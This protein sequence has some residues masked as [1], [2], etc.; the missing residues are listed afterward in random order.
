MILFLCHNPKST[1]CILLSAFMSQNYSLE[2][3]INGRKNATAKQTHL[4]LESLIM[5]SAATSPCREG[6]QSLWTSSAHPPATGWVCTPSDSLGLGYI[7]VSFYIF[8]RVDLFVF[9]W[10][11]VRHV[12]CVI[13]DKSFLMLQYPVCH[14]YE[15]LGSSSFSVFSRHCSIIP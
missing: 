6:Q 15:F 4:T 1:G 9:G 12:I 13:S 11:R 3:K 5:H 2:H 10:L 8:I 7:T 14:F